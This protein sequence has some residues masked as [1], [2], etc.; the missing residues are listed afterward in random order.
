MK[1]CCN[2]IILLML[3]PFS[4]AFA[5]NYAPVEQGSTIEFK[6]THQVIFKSTV[7]GTFTGIKGTI[8]FDPNNLSACSFNV[9]V[10]V[11]TIN[12]GINMRDNDLRKEKYFNQQKYPLITI[13]SQ[14]IAKGAGNNKY[15]LSASLTMKGVTKKISVPFT[16]VTANGGYHFNGHFE[17]NRLDF[18]V[19]PDN[20]IDKSVAVDL[21]VIAK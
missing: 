13:R 19:G 15:I 10:N 9:S 20:S 12:T 11:N 4:M 1:K 2:A 5:Q 14:S 21:F 7:T 8:V 3:L 18:N 16:A 17:L 6:V